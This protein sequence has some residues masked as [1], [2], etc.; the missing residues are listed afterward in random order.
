MS[1]RALAEADKSIMGFRGWSDPDEEDGYVH[2]QAPLAI[3]G[4]VVGG[5]FLGGGA[6]QTAP[7]RHVTFEISLLTHGG[8]RRQKLMRLDWRPLRGGHTN[9]RRYRCPECCPM[10]TNDTHF[11]SFDINWREAEQRMRGPK[12]P[13]AKDVEENL[14]S[15]EQLRQYVGNQFRINDIGVVGPPSWEYKLNV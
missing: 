1:L 7:D 3:N 15:Y 8:F 11:H 12:L 2:F 9:Q 10:R 5:L 14:Q 4:A 13:C 6:Y